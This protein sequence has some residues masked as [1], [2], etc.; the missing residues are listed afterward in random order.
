[1]TQEQYDNLVLA[2]ENSEGHIDFC[3]ENFVRLNPDVPNTSPD[4]L[5]WM[6]KVSHNHI[7]RVNEAARFEPVDCSDFDKGIIR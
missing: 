7:R 5:R 6:Q 1:M 2:V 4:W 3:R